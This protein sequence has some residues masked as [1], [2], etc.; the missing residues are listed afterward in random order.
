MLASTTP[1]ARLGTS[2]SLKEGMA[3]SRPVSHS[4]RQKNRGFHLVCQV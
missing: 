1:A 4:L 2:A 3:G